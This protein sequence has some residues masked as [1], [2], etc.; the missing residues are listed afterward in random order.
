MPPGDTGDPGPDMVEEM[1]PPLPLSRRIR[2]FR[3]RIAW[4][5]DPPL[6]RKRAARIIKGVLR[7][8][9]HRGICLCFKMEEGHYDGEAQCLVSLLIRDDSR[10][11]RERVKDLRWAI[12]NAFED[13]GLDDFSPMIFDYRI[14]TDYEDAY[15][16]LKAEEFCA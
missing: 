12:R 6:P 2:D 13:S 9:E 8:W 15:R 16:H 1:R 10:N 4:R 5:M 7:R 14:N 11:T 3:R